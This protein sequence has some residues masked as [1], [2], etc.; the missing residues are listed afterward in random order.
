[1]KLLPTHIELLAPLLMAVFAAVSAPSLADDPTESARMELIRIIE[2]DV[3][4]TSLELICYAILFLLK[5]RSM[6]ISTTN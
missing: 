6:H 1:M 3:R 5:H 2:E 4:Q